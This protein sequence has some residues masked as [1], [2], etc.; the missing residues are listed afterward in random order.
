MATGSVSA[1]APILFK[2]YTRQITQTSTSDTWDILD[3]GGVNPVVFPS[4]SGYSRMIFG[5]MTN[6]QDLVVTGWSLRTG[7]IPR[8]MTRKLST[9]SSV[10]ATLYAVLMYMPDRNT[11]I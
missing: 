6:T 7:D 3:D 8:W 2:Q 5:L 1:N 9:A 4:K 10:T 11:I